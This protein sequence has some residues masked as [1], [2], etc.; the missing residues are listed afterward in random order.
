M[1]RFDFLGN[2]SSGR[3]PKAGVVRMEGELLLTFA[4]TATLLLGFAM[5][6][7]AVA[8][9]EPRAFDRRIL[10]AM[11]SATDP[12]APIGPVWFQEMVR[13]FTAIG[14]TGVLLLV[15]LMV[16]GFLAMT[17]RRNAAL[18]VLASSAGGTLITH[19]TK[20][21]FARPRPD[22]VPHEVYV[23]TMSFPSGHAMMSAV[24]Y[25]TL[26]ALLARTEARRRVKIYILAMAVLLTLLVGASRIYLGVH[27]PTDVLA[28]WALGA[29]WAT[30][31][32]LVMLVLQRRGDVEAEDRGTGSEP[33]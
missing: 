31:C 18:M 25:L 33:S 23:D 24:V 11:R 29:G 28:G 12:S 2:L 7:A 17:R 1:G 6:G 14:S 27:W 16:A 5:L 22:L 26:G 13:D 20:I 8:G 4:G 19:L 9:G 3:P 21:G 15:V 32:W 30:L 10:L